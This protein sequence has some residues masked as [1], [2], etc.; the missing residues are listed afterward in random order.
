MKPIE[1]YVITEPMSALEIIK[2]RIIPLIQE[3]HTRMR[4]GDWIDTSG[5]C[6]SECGTTACIA[7]WTL[8]VTGIPHLSFAEEATKLVPPQ[9]RQ[10]F[11]ASFTGGTHFLL[12]DGTPTQAEAV[13]AFLTDFCNRHEKELRCWILDPTSSGLGSDEVDPYK[14]KESVA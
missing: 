8:I 3:D 6:G 14:P 2:E 13:V 7:G 5:D 12:P 9:L 1:S 10:K 4:M 11:R